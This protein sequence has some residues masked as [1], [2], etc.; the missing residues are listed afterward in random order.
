MARVLKFFQKIKDG[1]RS[2]RVETGSRFVEEKKQVWLGSE[3]YT[4]GEALTLL[5]VE[6]FTWYTD[7]SLRYVNQYLYWGV[8]R[9]EG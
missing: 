3:F 8:N 9:E 6:T 2:L 5:D 7:N 1:P 4:Y